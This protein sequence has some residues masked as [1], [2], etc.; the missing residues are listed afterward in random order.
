MHAADLAVKQ[1]LAASLCALTA[2][3]GA[4]TSDAPQ[5]PPPSREQLAAW[6]DVWR[7]S[8][9]LDG[10]RLDAIDAIFQD[11]FKSVAA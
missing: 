1:R 11:E 9:T 10:R 8:P 5:E 4:P 3:A 2:P 6:L 7:L